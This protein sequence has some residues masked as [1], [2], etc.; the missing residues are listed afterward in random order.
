V[1]K[2]C[3]FGSENVQNVEPN[4]NTLSRVQQVSIECM[5]ITARM[6]H[7]LKS[8]RNL[9]W[10]RGNARGTFGGPGTAF[11]VFHYFSCN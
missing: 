9:V 4:F 6:R 11:P 8:Q 5:L 2:V 7:N 3:I 10:G 1:I